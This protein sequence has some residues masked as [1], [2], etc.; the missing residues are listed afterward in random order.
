[1]YHVDLA[2]ILIKG[3][4]KWDILTYEREGFTSNKC[5][6]KAESIHCMQRCVYAGQYCAHALFFIF[7]QMSVYLRVISRD[8]L[9]RSCFYSF[10]LRLSSS[11][12]TMHCNFWSSHR[13]FF[14]FFV[15]VVVH[16]DTVLYCVDTK[17]QL[18]LRGERKRTKRLTRQISLHMLTNALINIQLFDDI[19]VPSD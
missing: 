11:K 4:S 13:S 1:M 15:D 18:E 10:L 12:I 3:Q 5:A 16:G 6:E 7:L 19:I 8:V 2:C 9:R 14:F 17:N